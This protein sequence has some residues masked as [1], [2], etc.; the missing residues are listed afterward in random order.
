[1]IRAR[2]AAVRTLLA[3]GLAGAAVL[4]PSAPAYALPAAPDP[5]P[6]VAQ[7][8]CLPPPTGTDGEIPWAQRQLAPE[9]V[10]DLTRG[11]GITV[12]VLDSG[13]DGQSPQIKGRVQRGVDT[14][15]SG[16]PGDRDCLGHGTFVAG[17][18]AAGSAE[19][20]GFAG[21]APEAQILPIKITN[22][23]EDGPIPALAE[24]IREAVDGGARVIN[25]SAGTATDDPG[26]K[27]AVEYAIERDVLIVA[28]APNDSGDSV[29]A[30]PA[31]YPGVLA[32]GAIDATGA[33][34]GFSQDGATVSLVA[35]GVDVVSIG[36]GGPGQWRGSGTSYATPFVAGTAALVRA[37]RPN[38]T[39][40]Q[41]RH[42]LQA[43][44]DFPAATLPDQG[45]GWGVVNPL[46]AVSTVLPEEGLAGNAVPRAQPARAPESAFSHP[47]APMLTFAVAT[48]VV[49]ATMAALLAVLGPVGHRR[50]WAPARE[51]VT[52]DQ[53]PPAKT[54]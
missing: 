14:T 35:P 47:V 28:A 11:A 38:L 12:A 23:P 37:Y 29:D 19:G 1:M 16:G 33:R 3:T 13:V 5:A 43:T 45:V 51:A 49:V 50:R 31:A 26:V 41:V 39:V 30:Y 27:S 44:A 22:T 54:S 34:A 20:A 53:Q 32:V 42:R 10:W 8:A 9:R 4:A 25:I 7:G 6:S 52:E 2:Y 15:G 36:P 21:M 24:G 18:I 40:E 17:I 46:A 48:L